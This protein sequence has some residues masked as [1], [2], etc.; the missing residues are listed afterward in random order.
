MAPS[1]ALQPSATGIPAEIPIAI[2]VTD[3]RASSNRSCDE[4]TEAMFKPP[5]TVIVVCPDADVSGSRSSSVAATGTRKR[6]IWDVLSGSSPSRWV[7]T[8]EV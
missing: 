3:C 5:V 2:R 4:L 6:F 1:R 8:A 7:E